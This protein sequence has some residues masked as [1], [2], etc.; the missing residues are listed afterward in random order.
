M[1][2]WRETVYGEL[3]IYH[4]FVLLFFNW[5]LE[6]ALAIGTGIMAFILF[7]ISREMALLNYTGK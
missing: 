3:L 2:F 4:V 7:K 6:L 1:G 5:P